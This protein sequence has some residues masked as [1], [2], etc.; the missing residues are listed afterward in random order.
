MSFYAFETATLARVG[1][2]KV[3]STAEAAALGVS[4]QALRSLVTSGRIASLMRG[5]YA[6]APPT[7]AQDRHRLMILAVT[8]AHDG[9]ML[10]AHHSAL[11]FLDLPTFGVDLRR[12]RLTRRTPGQTLVSHH[13][14]IGPPSPAFAILAPPVDAISVHPAIAVVQSGLTSGPMTA[15]VAADAALR[16]GL[17]TSAQLD[18]TLAAYRSRPGFGPV[19]SLLQIADGRRESAGE[20]RVAGCCFHL[21]YELVPQVEIDTDLG[22]KRVDFLVKGTKVIVEFDGRGKYVDPAALWEEK[23][24]EDALR[25]LGYVVVRLVWDDLANPARVGELIE[26]ALALARA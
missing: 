11:V 16:S 24:R 10:V 12:V 6:L 13:V 21:G 23:R 18:L 7:D 5:W 4:P 22:R 20:S 3:V 8:R 14:H 26:G 9:R 17:M 25:R 15:L 2:R 19:R 1:S